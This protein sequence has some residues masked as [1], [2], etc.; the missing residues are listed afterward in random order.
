MINPKNC[1]INRDRVK[2]EE[3]EEALARLGAS[4][5]AGLHQSLE[6]PF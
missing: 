5:R 2:A 1:G 4:L 3:E 6:R